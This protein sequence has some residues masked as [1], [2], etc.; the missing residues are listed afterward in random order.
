MKIKWTRIELT[1]E[2][3]KQLDPLFSYASKKFHNYAI[4]GQF[5]GY[6]DGKMTFHAVALPDDV[7]R[8]IE[9][10]V[11]AWKLSKKHPKKID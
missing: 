6:T 9:L 11:D 1:P 10:I 3:T 2:Q 7:S 4:L 5:A 8:Q